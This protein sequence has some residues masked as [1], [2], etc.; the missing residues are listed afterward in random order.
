MK[1]EC[2]TYAPA[3]GASVTRYTAV[4]LLL[5]AAMSAQNVPST[6]IGS[7][8]TGI[9]GLPKGAV[10]GHSVKAQHPRHLDISAISRE[11]NGS[12]VSITMFA[13]NGDPIAQGSGFFVS[14]DGRVVTNY[15]V[16][17]TGHY[18]VVKLPNGDY[19]AADD[20]LA[21]DKDRDVAI[22]KANGNDVW[23]APDGDWRKGTIKAHG[24]SLSTVTSRRFRSTPSRGGGCGDRQ[25]I[26]ARIDRFKRHC[27][28]DPDCRA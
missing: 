12:L 3:G 10:A 28:R 1:G 7:D 26:V 2:K 24:F 19:F 9:E 23:W 20:V 18:A 15:H 4:I 17:E 6:S 16:I 22:I 25:S 13:G 21:S 5:V 27:Q 14:E 11:A 8:T